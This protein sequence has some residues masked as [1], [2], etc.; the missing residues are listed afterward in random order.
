MWCTD[1][2]TTYPIRYIS[3][4]TPNPAIQSITT[5]A[6]IIIHGISSAEDTGYHCIV[7][8]SLHFMHLY[9]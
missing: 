7:I 8:Q 9:I 1:I 5:A 2:S 4:T 3:P 6:V